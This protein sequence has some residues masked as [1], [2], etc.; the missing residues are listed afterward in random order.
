[1]KKLFGILIVLTLILL[2]SCSSQKAYNFYL[3]DGTPALAV[4]SII[5]KS[6]ERIKLNFVNATEIAGA[7]SSSDCDMAI[8]PTISAASL[9]A[10]KNVKIKM[11]SNNVFGSL[12][13]ASK[14]K[15]ENVSGLKGHLVYATAGTTIDMLKYILDKNAIKYNMSSEIIADEVSITTASSAQE[16]IPLLNKNSEAFGVL[17][18]PVLSNALLNV[19]NLAIAL[20]LQ[21]EYGKINNTESYPQACFVAKDEMIDKHK[22]VILDVIELLKVNKEFL[23]QNIEALDSLYEKCNSSLKSISFNS[24]LI[25]RCNIDFKLA[26][27]IK[28]EVSS[29]VKDLGNIELDDEFYY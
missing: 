23:G 9:Y 14:T 10:K 13:L 29:Y 22:D 17:G 5:N 7:V 20:D 16:I 24:D 11:I 21:A 19:E 2:A 4:A 15:I 18:E 6:D 26:R 28:D 8:M 12:Y 1:M 27:D 25:S 3:P